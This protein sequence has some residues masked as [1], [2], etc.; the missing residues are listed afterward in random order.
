MRSERGDGRQ[1]LSNDLP[2]TADTMVIHFPPFT[3][4]PKN[5][6]CMVHCFVCLLFVHMFLSASLIF[7]VSLL[8]S[9]SLF[10][11]VPLL[12]L[13]TFALLSSSVSLL[14][15]FPC[16]P[17]SHCLCL[18]FSLSSCL[19]LSVCFSS[20]HLITYSGLFIPGVVG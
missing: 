5:L 2:A 4:I 14:R 11:F 19:H 16:L 18:S 8:L 1:E 10:L 13:C 9:V 6:F 15:L 20:V 7:F 17:V 12:T 3:S